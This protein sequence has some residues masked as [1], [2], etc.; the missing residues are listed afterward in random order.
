MKS[1]ESE[2]N[3]WAKLTSVNALYGRYEWKPSIASDGL[4]DLFGVRVMP[5]ETYFQ[6]HGSGDT[7]PAAHVARSSMDQVIYTLLAPSGE[8]DALDAR[9]MLMIETIGATDKMQACA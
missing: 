4:D 1:F 9:T 8:A 5:G 7:H 6:L 3:F 2:L